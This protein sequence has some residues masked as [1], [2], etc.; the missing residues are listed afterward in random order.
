MK[1]AVK[2]INKKFGRKEILNNINF[3]ISQGK[4]ISI[5][6]R[7]GSGKT[8][9]L[10]L[11]SG[12]YTLD[13]GEIE[14]DRK[15]I[16]KN[17]LKGEIIYIPDKFEYFKHSKIKN[18][19]KYYEL[20]YDNFDK[21]FLED[22]LRKNKIDLTKRISELSKGQLTI[23]SI[24]LGISCKTKFLLLDEP[25]DGID[26]VNIKLVIDY[27]L[28][29]QDSGVGILVSSHQL[30]YLENI[31]DKIIYL[32][33]ANGEVEQINKENYTKF[34]L[35]YNDSP[36]KSLLDNP[37]V[38]IVSNIGRVYVAIIRGNK[39]EARDYIQSSELL[40]YDELPVLLEDIFLLNNK[41]GEEDV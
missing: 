40:Q 1:L 36:P 15:N 9:L 19:I 5:V 6:G 13:G 35:V 26:V 20:A 10:K 33:E 24:I 31:S 4:I 29:A 37:K 2:N 28:D 18:A 23:F 27:I 32:G 17:N 8:T 22:E 16:E 3:E 34:Q 11:I 14:I 41:G 39:E 30:N 21:E 12:I 38:K 25:L 7:N